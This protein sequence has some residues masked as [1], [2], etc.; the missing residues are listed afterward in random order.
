MLSPFKET[1]FPLANL[2]KSFKISEIAITN[3]VYSISFLSTPVFPTAA[4]RLQVEGLLTLLLCLENIFHKAI[5]LAHVLPCHP[6]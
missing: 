2:M 4:K 6:L 3:L 1:L 5:Y